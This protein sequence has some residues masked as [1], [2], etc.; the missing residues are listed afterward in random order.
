M[1]KL[2]QQIWHSEPVQLTRTEITLATL[3]A[4]IM[5]LTLMEERPSVDIHFYR[6]LSAVIFLYAGCLVM[7]FIVVPALIRGERI[8]LNILLTL[9]L[10]A[11]PTALLG[12]VY[13]ALV[14]I[15]LF[16]VYTALRYAGLYLWRHADEIQAR[17]RYIS[18]VVL[19]ATVFW[20]LS[21]VFLWMNDADRVD[22]VTWAILTPM[23][24]A[25][26]SYSFYQLIPS[27][28]HGKYP[29]LLFIWKATKVLL[30]ITL[31]LVLL[32][33]LITYE[34]DAPMAI[35]AA[36][37]FL[38]LFV[39]A[40]LSW[41]LYKRFSKDHEEL[42]SLQEELGQSVAGFDF[43]RSQ[44]NPHF[45]F[46][47]LNSLYGLALQ[48][49][50]T[51]TS[52]GIQRLGDM[53]RFMLQE[54][55]QHKI[56]LAREVEYLRNYIALQSLRVGSHPGIVIETNIDQT[57][58]LGSV[59]PMLLIP[60]VENAFKH[61]ISFREQSY[62]TIS[63]TV[64]DGNLNFTVDNSRHPRVANDPEEQKSGIGL[65]NVRQR[66][67][68]LFPGKHQ[69]NIRETP[70]SFSIHLTIPVSLLVP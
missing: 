20:L 15:F 26:F 58:A 68:L 38:Q 57:L 45:L 34:E 18:P 62:I 59:P 36:N 6:G 9:I 60:F 28:A 37:F 63:L 43:L 41:M 5:V 35:A 29:F 8:M 7:N 48:E 49:N 51:R 19:F 61:G 69:L 14:S 65:V 31:P 33:F 39:T 30:L 50:A 10:F 12:D 54:N 25:M 17:Y 32:V 27:S 55:M 4:G 24:I 53:M 46:N 64:T 52:E 22:M 13:L 66:L 42:R 2:L 11:A 47:V 70:S 40:P 44:I 1:K 56:P 3:G 21:A 16:T 67:E 23:C